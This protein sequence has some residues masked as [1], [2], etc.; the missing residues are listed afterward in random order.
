MTYKF[1]EYK[2]SP[3]LKN[4]LNLGGADDKGNRIDITNLYLTRNGKPWIGVMGEFHF[5]RY[6][7]N[8]WYEELCKMRAGGVTAVATYLFWIYHEEIEGQFDFSGDLDIRAF[9]KDCEKA[10]LDVV[11]RIGPWAHGECRNGGFPDWL[12]KKPYPL[13]DNNPDYLQ[14]VKVWYEKI[15][16]QVK[17]LFYKDGGNIIAVQLENELV[18]NAEHLLMLKK[19][20]VETGFIVPIYT[21]TGWNS[22]YGAKIPVDEVLPVFG[23]YPEAPWTG[24]TKPLALS[25]HYVFN[26]IRNDSAV[27]V[28]LIEQ[29]DEDGWRLPYEKY[30]FATCELGGGIQVT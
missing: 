20:A 4:H 19:I 1:K 23:A 8:L 28:D 24:H 16:E 2:K 15:Y 30:P 9:V 17:G 7:R 10:G 22:A 18:N 29:T 5:S 6:D 27:G 26:K 13:R 12:L 11:V 14:K 25:P 3:L 21:V